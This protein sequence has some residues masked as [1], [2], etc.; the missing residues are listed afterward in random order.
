MT[1]TALCL[2]LVCFVLSWSYVSAEVTP[3]EKITL[4]EKMPEHPRLF[5]TKQ[6]EAE[7]KEQ[8]KTDPFL[9][10]LVNELIKKA[11]RVKAEPPTDYKIPDGIRLLNQSRRSIDR[12]TALA[13]AYRMTGN[14]EYADAAIEEMLTV[15]RFKDWNPSHYL[16]VAEMA[17]AVSLGY[18]WLYDV[19]PAEQREE[20]KAGLLKHALNTG[21]ELY[22]KGGWWTT[23][24]NN[25]NEV[26]NAGLTLAAL[27][28]A[29]DVK[30]VAEVI[31]GFT[32]RTQILA[33]SKSVSDERELA[34]TIVNYAVKS[35]PNGLSA[36]K[37]DG[38]YPEGPGYWAYGALFTGLMVMVLNDVFQSDFDLLKTEGL[39]VTGDYYMSVV[40]PRYRFFNYADGGDGASASPMMFALSHLYNRP[41][42]AVWLRT[43]LEKQ[44]RYTSGREAVFHALWYN[45]KGT[46]K[47]FADTP[48]AQKFSGI[49]DICMMRTAW[50]DPNAA[51]LG[52]KGGNNKA[53]H[54]H[55]DIGSFVYEVNG[56][57]WA[58]DLGADNYNLPGFWG[59][60]R[61][62]Y[63]RQNNRSHNTLVIDDK[64]QNPAA[65]CKI[66]EFEFGI[67]GLMGPIAPGRPILT[68]PN[69]YIIASAAVDMTDAYK[70]QVRYAIRTADLGKG[71]SVAIE[72][73]LNGVTEPVR[74]G[75]MT[76]ATIEL[77]ED[78]K[79]A[80]LSQGGKKLRVEVTT[81]DKAAKFEIVPATPPTEAEN[82]NKGYNMLT[83]VSIPQIE[84]KQLSIRVV[85]KPE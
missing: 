9:Q 74:W 44:N 83:I 59:Q 56:I 4:P 35:L 63:F 61:W 21:L 11:D 30:M 26:C 24:H 33:P 60:Q 6:K 71:G 3:L 84:S 45:P 2:C 10:K 25:W 72:D 47:D 55:L 58:V 36:Y 42:Y 46:D 14:K 52:F 85:M 48:L 73:A 20:I 41:D 49:Q 38:A 19:I 81:D 23:G 29:D 13:F 78:G 37:P 54:G 76:A 66:V 32:G 17:T 34:E 40:G 51:F 53:N 65:D 77:I 12:T 80:I 57:R 5:F 16:D 82:Q 68:I 28:V 62:D 1:K 67:G 79:T 64:I 7:I 69:A 22:K 75:M 8:M 31:T 50:N 18:D 39:A 15:C 43:F 70:G 27:A